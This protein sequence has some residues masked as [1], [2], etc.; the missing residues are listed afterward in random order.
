MPSIPFVKILHPM[1]TAQSDVIA[2]QVKE[3]FAQI[4]KAL[5]SSSSREELGVRT[6]AEDDSVEVTGGIE[7]VNELFHEQGWTDGLPIIPPTDENV[8]AMISFSPY[9]AEE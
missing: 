4:G 2:Q 5:A 3:A 6:G 8:R 1:A 9:S 7:E